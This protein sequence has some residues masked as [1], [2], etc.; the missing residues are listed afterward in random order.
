MEMSSSRRIW[1]PG[2]IAGLIAAVL[3]I[4]GVLHPGAGPAGGV[5]LPH[6]HGG[7][8]SEE[9]FKR[10]GTAVPFLGAASFSWFWVRRKRKSPSAPV[11]QGARLLSKLHPFLGW[12]ALALIA[13]HGTYF[14]LNK[15]GDSHI[16]SGLA[17]LVLLAALAAYGVIIRKVRNKW[18]R[19]VHR[20]LALLWVPALLLHAGGSAVLAVA[21]TL[22]AGG[23][24]WLLERAAGPDGR[25]SGPK[26]R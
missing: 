6:P 7:E 2:M 20:S 16:Y 21:V 17:A 9:W 5:R 15:P 11:R 12:A 22:A 13:V 24:V 19:S 10:M 23:L 14:L 25:T 4:A 3:L 8:G 1:I 18:T 26:S